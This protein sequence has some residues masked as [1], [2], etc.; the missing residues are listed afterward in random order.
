MQRLIIAAIC[1]IM[2]GG[3]I[4]KEIHQGNVIDPDSIWIIQKGDTRFAIE[5]EMGTP[6]IK[7]ASHPERALYIEYVVD[8]EADETYTRGVEVTYDQAWR[9]TNIRR[10]G[11]E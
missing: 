4:K 1:L 5:S 2:L 3:C 9:A 10:F 6:M 7:D 11:F 8:E